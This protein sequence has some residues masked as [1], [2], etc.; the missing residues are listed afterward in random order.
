MNNG[1][2]KK[3]SVI[4]FLLPNDPVRMWDLPVP[5]IKSGNVTNVYL[6]SEISSPDTYNELCHTLINAEPHETFIVNL[7]T[8]GGDLDSAIM[9]LDALRCTE[10]TTIAYLTGQ[11]SSAGTMITMGCKEVRIAEH[12]SFMIHNYSAQV[13]GK[14]NELV[15]RQDFMN[16]VLGKLMRDVYVGFLTQEEIESII[17]GSDFWF[18]SEEVLERWAYKT[19]VAVRGTKTKTAKRKHKE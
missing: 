16:R 14:G 7:N 19:G 3:M 15:A 1:G 9:I 5:I 17:E 2:I 6:T 10:A 11:V 18:D 13:S 8:P 4:P 12:S